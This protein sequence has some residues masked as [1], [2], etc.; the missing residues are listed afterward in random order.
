[1][2]VRVV[3]RPQ[4]DDEFAH[5][6]Q[7]AVDCAGYVPPSLVLGRDNGEGIVL[8]VDVVSPGSADGSQRGA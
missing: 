8:L 3:L 1:L 4:S 6:R 7:G 5:V 2:A